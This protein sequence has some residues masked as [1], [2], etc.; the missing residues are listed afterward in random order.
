MKQPKLYF[1]AAGLAAHIGGW[2]D[3]ELA[4]L[5]PLGGALFETHIFGE[6]TRYFKHRGREAEISFLRTRD[7]DEIDFLVDDARS[8]S[9]LEVKFGVPSGKELARLSRLRGERWREG[10]V[11]SLSQLCRE[12]V[13]LSED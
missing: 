6:L 11:L 12:K 5:G 8:I 9:P 4:R 10:T 13:A 7:G 3:A 1:L 2:R